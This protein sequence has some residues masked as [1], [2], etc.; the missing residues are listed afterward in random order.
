M[1]EHLDDN[2]YK[3]PTAYLTGAVLEDGLQKIA[4]AKSV[5]LKARKDLSSL[6]R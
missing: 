4:D 1:A 6:N 2:G 3:H 5:K